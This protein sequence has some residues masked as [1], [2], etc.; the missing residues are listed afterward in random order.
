MKT[1]GKTNTGTGVTSSVTAMPIGAASATNKPVKKAK[2]TMI[3]GL[4]YP[5]GQSPAEKA[6]A[7]KK[8][9]P[10]VAKGMFAASP[11]PISNSSFFLS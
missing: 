9:S 6:A 5:E 8:K 7:A 1:P 3:N 4:F 10:F 11:N 2:G